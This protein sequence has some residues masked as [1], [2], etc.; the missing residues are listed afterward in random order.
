MIEYDLAATLA[1]MLEPLPQVQFGTHL[2]HT[3]FLV[4][5]KVFAFLQGDGVALKLPKETVQQLVVT[6]YAA[7]LVM[8]KRVMKEWVIIKHERPEAYQQ[9]EALFKEA[10]RFVS[11]KA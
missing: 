11:S 10:I 3:N 6:N 4:S 2:H 5:N 1:S 9:D 7:P 8:G